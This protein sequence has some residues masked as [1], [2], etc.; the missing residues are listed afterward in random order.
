MNTASVQ[1]VL[2]AQTA[3]LGDVVLSTPLLAAIKQHD[4]NIFL[5]VLVRPPS[6]DL[7]K[8][9]P[10]IDML[11]TYDKYG[12]DKGLKGIRAISSRLKQECF[13]HAISPHSSLRVALVQYFAHI[14]VRMGFGRTLSAMFYTHKIGKRPGIHY[15]ER[16]LDFARALGFS[17]DNPQPQ[18]F[19]AEADFKQ[20]RAFLAHHKIDSSIPYIVM[21]PGS[22]WE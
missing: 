13:T 14:P 21:A 1:R 20:T 16:I 5:A 15:S 18:L 11:I 12:K 7:L 17:P 9:N 4:S 22:V 8:H 2:I 6:Q 10:H 19:P 3:F